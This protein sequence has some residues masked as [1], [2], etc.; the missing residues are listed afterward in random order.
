[1]HVSLHFVHRPVLVSSAFFVLEVWVFPLA[2]DCTAERHLRP[3]CALRALRRGFRVVF[4]CWSRACCCSLVSVGFRGFGVVV[5]VC[6]GSIMKGGFWLVGGVKF[7]G[8]LE[9]CAV[10]VGFVL[11]DK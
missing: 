10:L 1:M 7:S 11:F 8:R 2:G 6:L 3:G 4:G 5:L 9:M